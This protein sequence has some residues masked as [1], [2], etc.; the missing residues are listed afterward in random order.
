M[1][2]INI[3]Y[4]GVNPPLTPPRRGTGV[5]RGERRRNKRRIEGESFFV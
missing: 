5:R 3:N 1:Y 2:D 4:L